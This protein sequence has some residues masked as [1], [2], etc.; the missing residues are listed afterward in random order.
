M[1][2]KKYKHV[3]LVF[4]PNSLE[5]EGAKI[6]EENHKVLKS[7]V[8]K[9]SGKVNGIFVGKD[10]RVIVRV[11][12]QSEALFRTLLKSNPER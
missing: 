11:P 3:V 4:H 5:G 9:G 2:Q 10:G 6:S 7:E 1:L 12:D 8:V